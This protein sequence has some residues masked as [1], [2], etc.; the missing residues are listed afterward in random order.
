[1]IYLQHTDPVVCVPQHISRYGLFSVQLFLLTAICN[2]IYDY[3][4]LTVIGLTLYITS[5]FHWYKIKTTGF[6]KTLDVT[7]CIITI[8]YITFNDSAYFCP[9]NRKLWILSAIVSIISYLT[10]KYID[11]YQQFPKGTRY[12]AADEP[13]QYFSL[14]Y[15]WPNTLQRELS[16]KY[17][18]YVHIIL[19]HVNL[20]CACIYGVVTSP[21]CSNYYITN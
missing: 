4:V 14:K 3:N 2:Y 18:T 9:I 21:S 15:T 8:N 12:F 5:L 17:T 19:L 11:S 16:Y 6:F 7:T 1:M 10:N 13:Y 20:S